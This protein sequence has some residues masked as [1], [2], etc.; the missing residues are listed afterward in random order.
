MSEE[1]REVYEATTIAKMIAKVLKDNGITPSQ[2]HTAL[3]FLIAFDIRY[4]CCCSV[5]HYFS[6]LQPLVKHIIMLY[7]LVSQTRDER[8][9][10][11]E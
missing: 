6:R 5:E 8:G 9:E 11:R 2:L 1:C 10:V 3:P 7:E 4:V